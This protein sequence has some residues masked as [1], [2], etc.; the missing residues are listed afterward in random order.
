MMALV[1]IFMYGLMRGG[2]TMTSVARLTANRRN[3]QL[4][5]GPRTVQG[6]ARSS[7][8]AVTH[9]L[10]ARQL[11]LAD[12]DPAEY[13]LLAQRLL[14]AL[15]PDG[16][17]EELIAGQIVALAS[18]LRRAARVEVALYTIG[19]AGPVLEA[20]RRCGETDAAVGVAFASQATSFAVLSR[21]ETAMVNRLRRALAD[22]ERLQKD[23]ETTDTTFIVIDGER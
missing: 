21:Y 4:S 17:V 1:D 13:E 16:A 3:S 19:G 5:T 9:G 12:E 22:L 18:R 14:E 15:C 10:R 11:L 6:K 8:N 20:L 23:R 7:L 2:L